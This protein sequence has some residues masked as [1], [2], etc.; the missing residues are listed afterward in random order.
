MLLFATRLEQ[1]VDTSCV[2]L[3]CFEDGACAGAAWLHAL[4][5]RSS[6]GA[7]LGFGAS[8]GRHSGRLGRSRPISGQIWCWV[9]DQGRIG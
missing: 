2:E 5:P 7:C 1:V 4:P 6:M 3:R 8:C 9:L